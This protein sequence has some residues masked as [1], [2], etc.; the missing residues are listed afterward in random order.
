[1]V[2]RRLLSLSLIPA[3]TQPTP[4]RPPSVVMIGRGKE[5]HLALP[6]S[7]AGR[8]SAYCKGLRAH[9]AFTVSADVSKVTCAKCRARAVAL[10]YINA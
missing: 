9:R 3:M 6:S 8:P 10:G 2:Y 5:L 7:V 1:M 4:T